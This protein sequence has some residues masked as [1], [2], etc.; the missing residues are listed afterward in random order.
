MLGLD[1][2]VWDCG[3]NLLH[4]RGALDSFGTLVRGH[5]ETVR[6]ILLNRTVIFGQ[7][8]GVT[9]TGKVVLFSGEVRYSKTNNLDFLSC[10]TRFPYQLCNQNQ[11]L[12]KKT[13]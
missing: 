3:W 8:S 4:R 10:F 5:F 1:D 11:L 6:P 12:S 13:F 9:L 2:I 7:Q